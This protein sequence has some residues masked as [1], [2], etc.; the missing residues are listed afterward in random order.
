MMR[1]SAEFGRTPSIY[2]ITTLRPLNNQLPP[3][4]NPEVA[5]LRSI[6]GSKRALG[7]HQRAPGGPGLGPRQDTELEGAHKAHSQAAVEEKKLLLV[8]R[9]EKN[10][11]SGMAGR[12]QTSR[13]QKSIIHLAGLQSVNQ[14]SQSKTSPCG[15]K[16][17]KRLQNKREINPCHT[18]CVYMADVKRELPLLLENSPSRWFASSLYKFSRETQITDGCASPSPT[19]EGDLSQSPRLTSRSLLS[20]PPSREEMQ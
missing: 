6:L 8:R 3:H 7:C 15:G 13:S 18:Q 1:I 14:S 20:A 17:M 10:N 11:N 16:K 9:R 12:G 5:S 2:R 19:L 4:S